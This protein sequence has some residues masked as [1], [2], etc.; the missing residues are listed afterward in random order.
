MEI[1]IIEVLLYYY[2][3]LNT[4]NRWHTLNTSQDAFKENG[5]ALQR[6]YIHWPASIQEELHE[7]VADAFISTTI[8]ITLTNTS[9]IV[10]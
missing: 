3:L 4:D 5:I 1:R 9:I 10:L 7:V 2:H 6:V 8:V